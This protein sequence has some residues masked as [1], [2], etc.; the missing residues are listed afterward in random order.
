MS[1]RSKLHDLRTSGTGDGRT[2][3]TA[4]I[5]TVFEQA[6][7]GGELAPG[8][9]LPPTRHLAELAGVNHLTAARAY[10]QLAERGLVA[11]KV[12]SGTFVRAA[13]PVQDSGRVPD[14]IA[15]QRYVLPENDETYGDRV[16]AEMHG[17]VQTEGLIPLSVGYP[18]ER[19]FPV[20]RM[21]ELAA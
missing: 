14:S 9:K 6:I 17:H 1:Y 19:I 21:R 13:A 3:V 11:S 15:W 4:Q 12:G 16:L 7:A 20:E 10:R 8:A 5:V 18:S 2:G